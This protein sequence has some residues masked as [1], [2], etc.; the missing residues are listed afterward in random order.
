[1]FGALARGAAL[2]PVP[3]REVLVFKAPDRFRYIG[4]DNLSLIDNDDITTGKAVYG[5][6]AQVEGMA[7]AVVARPPV[8]GAKV[9]TFDATET[10]KVPGVLKVV[11]IDAS[12]IPSAFQPLGGIAVLAE[13]T[14]A[15]IKGRSLLDIQWEDGPNASYDS[16]Q[17]RRTMEAAASKPGK[18]V[19]RHGDIDAALARASRRIEASYYIPHLA[20]AP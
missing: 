20:Q 2:R 16:A 13:N 15:A 11:P 4:R 19:R 1:G 7:F 10:L 6:D 9:K 3:A 17:F 5:I 12:T 8:Y 18:V 14:F